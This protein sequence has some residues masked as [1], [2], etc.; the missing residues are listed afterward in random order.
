MYN[1]TDLFLYEIIEDF[2]QADTE[3]LRDEIFSS[4]CAAIWASGNKRR[5]YV[6][7]IRFRIPNERTDTETGRIFGQYSQIEYRYAR[8]TT[9]DCHWS[10]L[11]RQKINNLYTRYFDKEVIL[12]K[13]Y[14]ELL[15]TP[16]RLYYEWIS[17]EAR[18]EAD[19]L[20]EIQ[21]SLQKSEEV[22]KRLQREKMSLSWHEY[23]KVMETYLRRGLIRCQFLED[24]ETDGAMTRPLDFLNEDHFYVG[25]LCKRLGGNIKDYQKSYYGLKSSSRKGYTRCEQCGALIVKSNNRVRFCRDCRAERNREKT[26]ERMRA[27]RHASHK[28]GSDKQPAQNICLF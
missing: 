3:E 7:K 10:S 26:K 16:K 6:K 13:E 15:K 24:Y 2:K 18:K 12:D 4:F 1:C 28:I 25:Y 14:M 8:T 19:L 22:K 20:Y 17:G 5:T 27:R 23:K 11:L 21:S 9:K